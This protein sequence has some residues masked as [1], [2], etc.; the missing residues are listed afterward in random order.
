[1]NLPISTSSI[2]G[3][4]VAAI[5]GLIFGIL[6][7]K[8]RV[9]D[10]NVIVNMFRFKDFTVLKVMLTAI[11]V[12]GVGVAVM[13]AIGVIEGFHIKP[14]NLLGII[15]GSGIFG[16]GM[17]LYGYCPGTAIAA[18]ATGRI[19]AMVGFAGMIVGGILYA[20]SFSWVNANIL[21]VG[22]Y[23]KISLSDATGIPSVVWWVIIVS[24]SLVV[25][26]LIG[27]LSNKVIK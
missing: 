22:Q 3:L 17:V 26:S 6:L 9:T 16:V 18:I 19:H 7:N 14:T 5:L 20:M 25:F 24:V 4:I 12:G 2:G 23:G 11:I 1:M 10:Y 21:S 13:N 27:K 8:G 15:L